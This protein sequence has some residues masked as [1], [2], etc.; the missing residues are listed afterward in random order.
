MTTLDMYI[1]TLNNENTKVNYRV[2][3]KSMLDYIGKN[4]NEIILADLLAWKTDMVN[5]GK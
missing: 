3:I 2:D 1:G 4:E 5:S